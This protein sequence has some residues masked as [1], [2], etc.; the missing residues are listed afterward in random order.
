MAT[1]VTLFTGADSSATV[2]ES[3]QDLAFLIGPSSPTPTGTITFTLFGPDNVTCADPPI[4]T[5][6]H[7][8][9]NFQTYFSNLF[10]TTAVGTYRWVAMYSGDANYAPVSTNCNDPNESTVVV[11]AVPTLTTQVSQTSVLPGEPITDTAT[12]SGFNPTGTITFTLFGPNDAT[13]GGD[14]I[15]QDNVVVNG[16]GNYTSAS[17]TP[18]IQGTYRWVAS[19]SGDANNEAVSTACND[20]NEDFLVVCYLS[21]TLILTP[22]GEIPIEELRIGDHVLTLSVNKLVK[23][24]I[25]WIGTLTP[26]VLNEKSYPI[27]I[28]KSARGKNL[29]HRD[30]YVSPNHG[31]FIDNRLIL[32]KLLVN[33][34]NIYQDKTIRE[35]KY[36][37]IEL[38]D[39]SIIVAEGIYAE[40]YLDVNNR[41]TFDNSKNVAKENLV[42]KRCAKYIRTY[43]K[44]EPYLRKLRNNKITEC[45]Y[46]LDR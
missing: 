33:D 40:S 43:E 24:K 37:H 25:K 21:G 45:N 34:K 2:G 17:F 20:P 35:V 19:Y 5:S 22:D 41:N 4:F 14:P 39:H 18:T 11:Q 29:P 3:I 46:F 32:A 26:K 8:V 31:I 6:V 27:K 10:Q 42:S 7:P 12:L 16:N 30:L 15:F 36:Y 38:D 44:A 23:S 9:N 28:C 1:N 13:C